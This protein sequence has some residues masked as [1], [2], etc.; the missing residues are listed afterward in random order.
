MLNFKIRRLDNVK[1][2]V[3]EL[4]EYYN[5]I[6]QDYQHMKWVPPGQMAKQAYSWAIQT[7]LKDP[8]QPCGPY[9]WPGE[10]TSQFNNNYDT[11]TEMI[12]GF[13]KKVIDLFPGVKQT[14]I[15]THAPGTI[16]EFHIDTELEL[17]PHVKVHIPIETNSS[18]F[19]QFDDEEFHLEVGYAY[20]VNT[21]IIHGTNNK[22]STER[23]HLIFKIPL[24]K[25]SELLTT[26]YEI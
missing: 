9:H 14:N 6:K 16:I 1:F 21:G 2:S 26:H 8:T 3:N 17:E 10:D 23:A 15:T 24:S 13:G 22:G 7:K 18:S 25:V 4:V 12:F 5:I 11:P 19:L 20:L